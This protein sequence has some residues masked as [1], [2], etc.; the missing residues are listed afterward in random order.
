[1]LLLAIHIFSEL[2]AD[3]YSSGLRVVVSTGLNTSGGLLAVHWTDGHGWV[4]WLD[5]AGA[6]LMPQSAF[7]TSSAACVLDISELAIHTLWQLSNEQFF[8]Q[9][10]PQVFADR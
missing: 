2:A 4:Q 5:A 6:L 1:M 3:V 10:S 7:N 8:K 9:L